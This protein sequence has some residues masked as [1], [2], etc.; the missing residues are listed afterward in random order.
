MTDPLAPFSTP[1]DLP[2]IYYTSSVSLVSIHPCFLDIPSYSICFGPIRPVAPHR[3]EM[4]FF[5]FVLF[6]FCSH[7][8][9]HFSSCSSLLPDYDI[10]LPCTHAHTSYVSHRNV[11]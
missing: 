4:Y 8:S 7:S 5:F 10:P 6:T 3:N 11:L 1:F 9:Y 2:S